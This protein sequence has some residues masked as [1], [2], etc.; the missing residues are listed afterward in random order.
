MQNYDNIGSSPTEE[1]CAQ[2]GSMGY[3]QQ[4]RRE[5]N[6]FKNQ[7]L[8]AFGTPPGNASLSI[9]SFPHDFGSYLE[10]ICNYDDESETE[11]EYNLKC[12]DETPSHWD[13][14]ALAELSPESPIR[15]EEPS[16]EQLE[17]WVFDG[18]C[19][20]TDGCLVEPDGICCHG[21][22]SWLLELGII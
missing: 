19:E 12:I 7:L 11:S 20:A 9:K 16:M 22:K 10:V 18:E 4:A 21:C 5:C 15:Q 8:R 1:N 6:A 13:N 2:V 3:E 14:E 17:Q